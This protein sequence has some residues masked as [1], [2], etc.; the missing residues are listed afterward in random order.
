VSRGELDGGSGHRSRATRDSCL[1]SRTFA[2]VECGLTQ[3]VEQWARR[4]MGLGRGIR[5]PQLS[6]RIMGEQWG[7]FLPST[8]QQVDE[9]RRTCEISLDG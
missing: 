7:H 4:L 5:G 3:S 8:L 1:C 6:M 9:V 2:G